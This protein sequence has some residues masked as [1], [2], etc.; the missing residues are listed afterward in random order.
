VL[1]RI[2]VE[3]HGSREAEVE[4]LKHRRRRESATP[5]PALSERPTPTRGG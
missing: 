4:P 2:Y 3:L 1:E 5:P